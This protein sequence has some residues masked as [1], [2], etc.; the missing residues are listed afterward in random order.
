M[1]YLPVPRLLSCL[2]S[3]CHS[4]LE[5]MR[6]RS[7]LG[8]V[9]CPVCRQDE[10]VKGVKYLP[11]DVTSLKEVLKQTST[12]VL[13]T[14]SRCYDDVPSY[15]W[16]STCSSALCEFHHQDHKLSVDTSKH[17][18][19]T[20]KEITARHKHVEPKLP[21]PSCPEVLLQD[22]GA[23]CKT[24]SH[25][26]SVQACLQ[27]HVGH[28]TESCVGLFAP[29]KE[30]VKA[31]IYTA[32]SEGNRLK[33]GAVAIREALRQLDDETDRAA[34]DIRDEMESLRRELAEREEALYK[35]LQLVSDRKRVMLTGQLAS[36]AE[37][38]EAF[39]WTAEVAGRILADTEQ[40]EGSDERSAYLVAAAGAVER[41]AKE[42]TEKTK[43][44]PLDPMCDTTIAVS[45]NYS[46]LE[47][48]RLNLPILGCIQVAEEL[49]EMGKDD[50]K[51]PELTLYHSKRKANKHLVAPAATPQICFSIKAEPVQTVLNERTHGPGPLNKGV[52]SSSIVIEA[53]AA[54]DPS[55]GSKATPGQ[56][57]LLGQVIFTTETDKRL[58]AKQEQR[59][60]FESVVVRNIPVM[61]IVREVVVPTGH[62]S[63][64]SLHSS[65]SKGRL[66]K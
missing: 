23:Y 55:D 28:E 59:S 1:D 52:S 7:T 26:L 39:Q 66:F 44:V 47:A 27:N 6:E 25:V 8:K 51:D 54:L 36:V 53:R 56:G 48:I 65:P 64:T 60:F 15:S 33:L 18:I 30:S 35:R 42:T 12:E 21:P 2:H 17:D 38:L 3:C 61:K 63:T 22:C 40:P 14:C 11:L 4:C 58:L 31:S 37:N 16:C 43:A 49:N 32:E 62:S 9:I 5:D 10:V 13:S 19:L 34:R 46:E 24:C 57:A 45:F 41:H 29:M 50:A 20:F